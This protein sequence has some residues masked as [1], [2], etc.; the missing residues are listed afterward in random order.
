MRYLL[1]V[2]L[3]CS[4]Y[5]GGCVSPAKPVGHQELSGPLDGEYD[6]VIHST[7]FGPLRTTMTA[8]ALRPDSKG[9]ISFNAN[10]RPDIAWNLIGGASETLGPLF[11]PYIFPSGMLIVWNSTMPRD[12][13][14]GEGWL[15]VSRVGPF[16]A[17]TIIERAGGPVSIVAKDGRV[18][19]VMTYQRR[20]PLDSPRGA[21]AN[22]V[23]LSDSISR[24]A[25]Q[26]LYD[27]KMASS[28]EF[29][30]YCANV[31]E[32]ASMV[33][34]DIEFAFAGALAWRN[35]RNLPLPLVY[36]PTS[37][38]SR[39]ILKQA[40]S[41]VEQLRS[42]FDAKTGIMTIEVVATMDAAQV[43]EIMIDA[44]SKQPKA[45]ILDLRDCVG[46]D[47]STLR[48]GC[49]F[50]HS[51]VDI[52][53]FVGRDHRESSTRPAPLLIGGIADVDAAHRAL[54][55]DGEVAVTL[56][57]APGAFSGPL[58]VL[59]TSRTRSSGEVLANALR[60]RDGVRYFGAKTASRPRM[61]FEIPLEQG[62]L[63]RV[64]QFE[65]R[66]PGGKL[67]VCDVKPDVRCSMEEAP[68]KAQAWL[69]PDE[70][71]EQAAAEV[72]K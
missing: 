49:W 66:A 55:R 17:K 19:A 41:T 42:T 45:V 38:E 48:I 23:S 5:I 22:Y 65:W 2:V 14:P 6:V 64:P 28:A 20:D 67:G 30:E 50:I 1:A 59:V 36:R 31:R 16:G 27:P 29:A 60:D 7:W 63:L 8:Q 3:L 46:F 10:T 70:K 68:V 69:V 53:T 15:G 34:D 13:K 25:M 62:Y 33:Q 12:G 56:S 47:L 44:L 4:L 18:I 52:G 71:I 72:A 26:Q 9:V 35:H 11:V 51:P 21:I 61:G 37:D 54:E 24:T 40:G 32:T 57:P 43:D 58:A 39:R